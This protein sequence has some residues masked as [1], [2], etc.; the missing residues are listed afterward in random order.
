M[1]VGLVT[2]AAGFAGALFCGAPH[3]IQ[4]LIGLGGTVDLSATLVAILFSGHIVDFSFI[5]ENHMPV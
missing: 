3:F 1:P 4:F 5:T 2:L